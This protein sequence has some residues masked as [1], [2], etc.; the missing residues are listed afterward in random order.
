MPSPSPDS[1]FLALRF[2]TTIRHNF[3]QTAFLS[4]S[5]ESLPN[6]ENT[7]DYRINSETALVAPLAG[8]LALK[9]TYL[10]HY[11]NVPEPGFG[12]TDRI[13]TSGIQIGF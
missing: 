6:V 3:T 10:V 12:K 13:L 4:E 11:D 5:A 7:K 8:R 9:I 1:R 2:A